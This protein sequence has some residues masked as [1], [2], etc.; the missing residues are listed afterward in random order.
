MRKSIADIIIP[1]TRKRTL[2]QNAVEELASS[3]KE[4]GLL[5]PITVTP[6]NVLISGLH[7]LEAC[8]L[9]GWHEIDCIIKDYDTID[10]E[11]AEIDENLIRAELTVLQRAEHL[12]RRKEIYEAKYPEAK[13]EERKRANLKQYRNAPGALR[14]NTPSAFTTDTAKK[15]GLSPRTIQED[16][17]IAEKLTGEV[18]E[19]ICG[20][21]WEDSKKELLD[22]ARMEPDEQINVVRLL[23][24]GEAKNPRG[25]KRKLKADQL[26][27]NPPLPEGKYDV[28]LADPP[29]QYEF[30][31]TENRAIENHYPTMTLEEIKALEIPAADDAVLLLWATAPKLEEALEVMRAWGFTY[32]TCAVWDKEIIGMGYW[33]RGQHELLLLGTKGNFPAPLPNNRFSSV[34][35]E[36]RGA[37]SAKPA[38]VYE[39][40]EHMFP[41]R[42]YLELFARNTRPGWGVW[43]NEVA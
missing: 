32:R 9:L 12:K 1:A 21:P 33:F 6:D 37:H 15:T 27:D 36:R 38:V 28:I 20:T 30:V 5:N 39:M 35:R 7:R 43:G 16:I 17:Q 25:A 13:A 22:I 2:N 18:K 29:W 31:E 11:L 14:E 19:A 34:I 24:S 3:I 10:A 41:N 42:R 23:I 26:K 4:I 40:I 8:K